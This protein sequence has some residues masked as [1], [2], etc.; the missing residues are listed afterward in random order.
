MLPSR[1][2]LTS[3]NPDSL[4][5]AATSISSAGKS[6]YDAARNLDDGCDR[7]PESRTW[8]GSAHDAAT[9]MF[10]RATERASRFL[11]YT[12]AVADALTR[13][14]ASIGKARTELLHEAAETDKGELNVTDSWVVL[15]DPAGMSAEKA[16]DLQKQAELAQGEINRLLTAVGE[17]DEQT[18]Q[19]LLSARTGSDTGAA[20]NDVQI[21]G[22]RVIPPSPENEVPDPS[23]DEGRKLQ[24]VVSAED[25]ATS[26]REITEV[27]DEDGNFIKTVTMLDGS[28][29]V[30][31]EFSGLPYGRS[32]VEGTVEVRHFDKNG[33]LVSQSHSTESED[34]TKTT[35]FWW[36][37]ETQVT[38]T[39]GPD[40][41]CR[42]GVITADG[43]EGVLPEQFFTDPLP[44]TAGGFLSGLE[45]QADRGIPRLSAEAIDDVKV[46][47]K[48]GGPA[49]GFLTALY[50]VSEQQTLH[51]VCA[52][53]VS[54]VTGM[55]GGYATGAAFAAGASAAGLPFLAP[56]AAMGGEM[57]GG[58]TFGYVGKI[59]GNI[60]CPE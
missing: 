43:R 4:S 31:T 2:R 26:V 46:G 49:V 60:V 36:S 42:G 34:G 21:P 37:D 41:T 14:G 7:L 53:A 58:W 45:K 5:A 39:Q 25:M 27:E 29:Q 56:A 15:I 18:A 1:S 12:D 48:F 38:I 54:G 57:L 40:G 13:G 52:E 9:Q 47:A 35:R 3:W 32:Y 8:S 19:A 20:F 22:P 28:K 50:N 59:V 10:G 16:A 44:T 55:V 11:D 17:A 24:Q 30:V 51:D 6:V 23:T 33:N